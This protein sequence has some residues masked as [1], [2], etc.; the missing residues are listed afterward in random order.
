MVKG[1]PD[2]NFFKGICEEYVL[3]KHHQDKF[4]KGKTHKASSPL[5]LIHIDLMGH[6]L[7]PL[8]SKERYVLIFVDDFSCYTWTFFL[9]KNSEVFQHLKDFKSLVETQSRR[10]IKFLQTDN[11]GEYV[12][13]EVYNLFLESG[14]QL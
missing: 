12:N 9:R 3:G 14:I 7:H 8:I 5:D 2:I 13:H 1:L 6:F 4:D 10:K 11:G